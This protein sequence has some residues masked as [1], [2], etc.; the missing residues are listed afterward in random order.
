VVEAVSGDGGREAGRA[1][2]GPAG[3]SAGATVFCMFVPLVAVVLYVGWR[4]R[5]E[6]YLTAES[7]LGYALGVSGAAAMLLLLLYSARKRIG[8]LRGWGRLRPWLDVHTALGVAG[9]ALVLLHCNFRIGSVNSS[10]ALGSMMLVASSGFVGRYLYVRI[11]R[12]LDGRRASL[13]E[14]QHGLSQRYGATPASSDSASSSHAMLS[15]YAAAAIT[16]PPGLF[17]ALG[18]A[19]D[20][21]I[22]TRLSYPRLVRRLERESRR[23]SDCGN[24][25]M[26]RRRVRRDN[27]RFVRAYLASV[28]EVATF[29]CYERLFSLWHVVHIPLFLMMVG[30]T[31]VHVVAVHMY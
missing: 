30:A 3:A 23:S 5:D 16:R 20:A 13:E 2:F 14:L 10:V 26:S 27:R 4:H 11:H 19:V 17:S 1:R 24:G 31:V 6:G 22:R 21:T 7:G 25:W 15:G 29:A 8:W 28:R 9:P 18:T 12:G